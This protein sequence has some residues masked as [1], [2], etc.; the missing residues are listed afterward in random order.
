MPEAIEQIIFDFDGVILDSAVLKTRAFAEVYAGEDPAKL[1]AIVE[2]QEAHGGVGRAEKFRYFERALFG[3]PAGE[4]AI[5]DLCS[6]FGMRIEAAMREAPFVPG[7]RQLLERWHGE[8]GM[9]VVSGTPDSELRSIVAERGLS[10][11]FQS[12]YG[13]PTTKIDAFRHILDATGAKAAR[14]LA[15]GDSSTEFDAAEAL[16]IPFLAIVPPGATDR[17]PASIAKLPDL[18]TAM[19]FSTLGNWFRGARSCAP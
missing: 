11:F 15:I 12:L 8:V 6:R 3:R 4:E 7:A 16:G 19:N 18:T 5:A 9:H 17:F 10:A 14:T 2:Y 13:S 1:A